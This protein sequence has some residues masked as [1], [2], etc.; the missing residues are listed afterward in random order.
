MV[1]KLIANSAEDL[2]SVN[3]TVHNDADWNNTRST[4]GGVIHLNGTLLQAWSRT[5]NQTA[6]SSCES[7]F[8][9]IVT[10]VTETIFIRSILNELE[11]MKNRQVQVKVYTDS[12]S[13]MQLAQRQGVGRVKHLNI[14]KLFVQDL[15]KEGV[16]T[17]HRVSTD[18]NVADIFTKY[19]P[20]N[21]FQRHYRTLGLR[22]EEAVPDPSQ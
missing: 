9:A 22:Q 11:P 21:V 13:A 3:F 17:I 6:L 7:E 1:L 10:G 12:T 18:E 15:V 16:V 14:R 5:Q 8:Y 2:E 19:L 20:V 4:S